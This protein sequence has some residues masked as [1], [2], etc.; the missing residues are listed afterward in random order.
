MEWDDANLF[1]EIRDAEIK[2]LSVLI[3][4]FYSFDKFSTF[5]HNN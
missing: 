1:H 5:L 4:K 3:C 2:V